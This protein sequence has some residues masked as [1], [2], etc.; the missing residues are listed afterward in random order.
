MGGLGNRIYESKDS[1]SNFYI[2]REAL[3]IGMGRPENEEYSKNGK[4]I[5][6]RDLSRELAMHRNRFIKQGY[7]DFMRAFISSQG[8]ENVDEEYEKV[9]EHLKRISKNKNLNS[10]LE[11]IIDSI[12]K[13]FNAGIDDLFNNVNI[14]NESI[15]ALQEMVNSGV[16]V[17]NASAALKNSPSHNIEDKDNFIE[18]LNDFFKKIEELYAK[19]N[20]ETMNPSIFALFKDNFDKINSKGN[21]S[22]KTIFE[23]L[24]GDINENN[25][26]EESIYYKDVVQFKNILADVL[27]VD[28]DNPNKNWKNNDIKTALEKNFFAKGLGEQFIL[29]CVGA[30]FSNILDKTFFSLTGETQRKNRFGNT[31]RAGKSDSS[32]VY[33]DGF[34]RITTN[35]KGE[36]GNFI[37]LDIKNISVSS[38]MYLLGNSNKKEIS[39]GSPGFSLGRALE[40]LYKEQEQQYYIYNMFSH[41][42]EY[43][44][45]IDTLH[46]IMLRRYFVNFISSRDLKEFAS[47]MN[48]NGKFYSVFNIFSSI[49]KQNEIIGGHLSNSESPMKVSFIGSYSVGKRKNNNSISEINKNVR[50]IGMEGK[51]YFGNLQTVVNHSVNLSSA[52]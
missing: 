42:E 25:Y 39:L 21:L 20:K 3:H 45:S 31:P 15:T 52:I 48:I 14:Q 38:K 34:F 16:A 7:L 10:S 29:N 9:K 19:F 44:E 30:G 1:Q 36:K 4:Y 47:L 5:N 33:D 49:L 46:D 2:H 43:T 28:K 50:S 13:S 23:Q 41:F 17:Y 40:D 26:N 37:E 51:L 27:N 11:D 18:G 35:T 12:G 6:D 24:V 8:V 32:F 22:R